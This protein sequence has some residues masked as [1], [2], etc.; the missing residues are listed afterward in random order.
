MADGLSTWLLIQTEREY[1][2]I[3]ND[4]T[5]EMFDSIHG[6]LESAPRMPISERLR[7]LGATPST[8]TIGADFHLHAPASFAISTI[9]IE[10]SALRKP[11]GNSEGSRRRGRGHRARPW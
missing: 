7:P 3:A 5:S 4:R 1:D 9:D 8:A 6:W 10:L 11:R 2:G